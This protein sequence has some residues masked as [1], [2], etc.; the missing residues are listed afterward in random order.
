MDWLTKNLTF[1][2]IILIIQ[3]VAFA[4]TLMFTVKQ[5][6]EIIIEKYK[7]KRAE[8]EA[9]TKDE[10]IADTR[11]ELEWMRNAVMDI[12]MESKLSPETKKN[13]MNTYTQLNNKVRAVVD[14][15]E[16]L[17]DKF[18]ETVKEGVEAVSG[19]IGSVK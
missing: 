1:D 7:R 14:K 4:A 5:R 9:I 15:V 13:H 8:N 16:E 3:M 17:D 2:R 11:A 18:I 6:V 19:I 12:I 10:V